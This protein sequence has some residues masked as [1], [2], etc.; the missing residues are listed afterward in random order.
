MTKHMRLLTWLMVCIITC[1]AV[2]LL[3]HYSFKEKGPFIPLK[4]TPKNLP[5]QNIQAIHDV[6]EDIHSRYRYEQLR[7]ADPT[8]H[9]IPQNIRLRELSFAKKMTRNTQARFRTKAQQWLQ[10]GPFNIGGRTRALA[11]DISNEQVILAGGASGG[12]WRSE[13]NGNTWTKTNGEELVQSTTAIIQDTRTGKT[14]TWYY[15]TG[16]LR[17][18]TAAGG[19]G[20]LYR[21]NGIF[22]STDGGKSWDILPAT[23]NTTPEAYDNTFEYIWNLAI[24]TSNVAEDEIYA[25]GFGAINR[26]TDGG[27]TWARVLGNDKNFVA[28][29][30]SVTVSPTGIV[31]ATLSN[32]AVANAGGAD[33]VKGF[34]RSVDG[35]T[36]TEITPPSLPVIH[37]RTVLAL[38]PTNENEVYFL[39]N[40]PA[41][42]GVLKYSLW[43]Y[44]YLA[45]DGSGTGGQWENLSANIPLLGGDLGD[46]DSQQSYNM[47]IAFKPDDPHMMFIGGTNLYRSTNGFRSTAGTTWIGGYNPDGGFGFYEN[48]HPD[49][50]KLVFYPSDPNKM[51]SGT[52]GGVF[53]TNS[54]SSSNVTWSSLNKGYFTTQFYSVAI[55]PQTD[56]VVGGMQDN[57]TYNTTSSN[58]N[59]AWTRLLGGDG[60][61]CAVGPQSVYVSA[62]HGQIF[63]LA[64]DNEG[65]YQGFA[66]VDPALGNG[67]AFINPFIINPNNQ[68]EMYLPTADTLWH[69][70]NISEIKLGSN[71]KSTTNWSIIDRLPN[72]D[73]QITA[74]NLSQA[75]KNTLYYGTSSGKLYKMNN[76]NNTQRQ[77]L[78]I[79]GSNFP[80]GGYISSIALNPLNKDEVLIAFSN[81][82]IQS[83][84]HS[85]DAGATWTEVGGNLEE[86]PDG[87]GSGP[88]VRWVTILPLANNETAYLT[89]TSVGLFSSATMNGVSTSW[90]QE[91]KTTIGNAVVD[92]IQARLTDGMVAVATHGRGIF[93]TRY[94]NSFGIPSTDGFALEQNFPNPFKTVTTIKYRLDQDAQVKL[95]IY[96]TQGKLINVLVNTR[97]TAGNKTVIWN[98]ETGRGRSTISGVY[99]YELRVDDKRR[100]KRMFLK[101]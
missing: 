32:T 45:G 41:A 27:N 54:N 97:Q 51:L 63:R 12:M 11:I 39:T 30:T 92:M 38:S 22:K 26:S 20:A 24:D 13:N 78:D 68:F 71:S 83:L 101:K 36:W 18:N 28:R 19:G 48:H 33:M 44:T 89:G 55:D 57:G 8:T 85:N 1:L 56:F 53:L 61:F 74:L 15:G 70:S 3:K 95:R 91:G 65:K 72:P 17:G 93:S 35:V 73:D 10:R 29:F 76:T 4:K 64:Y 46:Y 62:Q 31:Y 69:N 94:A 90:V 7:L 59:Q 23:T 99:F 42:S 88:S 84:F 79:T 60:A 9:K 81:Y 66:R 2:F 100:T 50:H 96:D 77:R 75:E 82:N 67:Y 6:K 16:E 52:D 37:D 34:Y 86:K 21:G 58:V 87:T 14:N 40:T 5:V 80:T 98:G 43:K 25:A 49:I 47:L